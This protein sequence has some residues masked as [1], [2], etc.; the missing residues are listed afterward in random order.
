MIAISSLALVGCGLYD[1][2]V[3]WGIRGG[4]GIGALVLASAGLL[5]LGRKV[6]DNFR[7]Y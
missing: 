2:F 5:H 3:K 6:V 4:L 7:Y 1:G